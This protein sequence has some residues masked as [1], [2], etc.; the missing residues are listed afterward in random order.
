[1]KEV[2]AI[3]RTYYDFSSYEETSEYH[4]EKAK[5]DPIRIERLWQW[6]TAAILNTP[7]VLPNGETYRWT[8]NGFGSGFMMTQLLDSFCNT[9]MLLTCLIALGIRVEDEQFWLLVQGDDSIIAFCEYVYGPHFIQQLEASA[10]FY[11]N[12]RL[13]TKKSKCSNDFQDHTILGYLIKNQMPY[14]TDEDLLRHLL[15]PETEKNNWNRQVSVLIGLAYASC[16]MNDTFFEFAEYCYNKL[17]AK[18]DEP[19]LKY[20]KWFER[21]GIMETEDLDLLTFPN[22]LDLIGQLWTPKSRTDKMRQRI[23]PTR[24]GPRKE[25]YFLH[26]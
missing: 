1:M 11:F 18:G 2:F 4:D 9:I 26:D 6:M 22:Q 14:R 25:F 7:I 21:A 3:W 16:G 8:R 19:S 12:A 20:L 24:P 13:G 17:R 10:L 5:A 23:W 15:F